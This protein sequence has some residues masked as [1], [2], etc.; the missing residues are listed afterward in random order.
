MSKR[1]DIINEIKKLEERKEL[2]E[3]IL[4]DMSSHYFEELMIDFCVNSRDF[5]IHSEGE[6][7]TVHDDIFNGY[8]QDELEWTTK[9]IDNLIKDLSNEM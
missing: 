3:G 9:R 1:L 5:N 4:K 8:I 2:L 7:M 6:R